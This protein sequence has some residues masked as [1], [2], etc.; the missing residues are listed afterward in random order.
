MARLHV[1]P[2]GGRLYRLSAPFLRLPIG[3]TFRQGP[4]GSPETL[5]RR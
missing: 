4:L 1:T 3:V 2:G 5:H